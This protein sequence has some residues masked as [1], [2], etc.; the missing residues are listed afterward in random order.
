MLPVSRIGVSALVDELVDRGTFVEWGP[1]DLGIELDPGP[2]EGEYASELAKAREA[3]GRTESV[4]VGTADI[5][6]DR[7]VLLLGDFDFLAGSV[8]RAACQLVIAAF[9]KASELKL[10]VFASPASGG[11]RMQEG[12]AA[13]VLMADVAAAAHRFRG[14]GN[15]LVVWLRNPTTGGVMATWGSLGSV[16]FG[17]PGALTGFLGPRV[18]QELMGEPFPANVQTPTNLAD[19]GVIDSAIEFSD[20]RRTVVNVFTVLSKRDH[21]TEHANPAAPETSLST[22]D[23]WEC[24]LRTREPDRPTSAT[25]LQQNLTDVTLLSGTTEGQRSDAVTLAL[26]CWRGVAVLVVAQDRAAQASGS[27]LN[28][29]S[30]RTARR[31]FELANELGLPVVSIVDTAGAELSVDAE[32]NAL[33]GEIARC[34]ADLTSVAVP[35]VSVLLGMGCGGAALAMLPADRVVSAEHGWVSPLP[36]EGAS[37]IRYRTPDRASEMA[38]SQEVAAWQLAERGI[39]DVVVREDRIAPSEQ[40][41]FVDVVGRVVEYELTSLQRQDSSERLARRRARYHAGLANG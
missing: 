38:R 28:P 27:P 36:L 11:T 26:G 5:A 10:P 41:G 30:L 33:A 14:T 3:T 21:S 7:T 19:H 8:G 12:T 23:P 24:V 9:D 22:P 16:T 34:L 6:G 2:P 39:V 35:T 31:G 25:L 29:A 32:Q 40:P 17:E 37:I 18:Y 15:A 4:V 1:A 13:F 20:L